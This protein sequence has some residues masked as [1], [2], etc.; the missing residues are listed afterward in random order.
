MRQAL[1]VILALALLGP[2]TDVRPAAAQQVEATLTILAGSVS[3]QPAAGG[4]VAPASE[5]MDVRNGDRVKTD[6]D[7]IALLTFVDGST[8]TMQPETEITV[9]RTGG[10]NESSRTSITIIL[11]TV[12]ARVVKLFDAQSEFTLEG[13][14]A[15]ATVRGSEIG[16]RQNADGTFVCWTRSGTMTVTGQG[17]S[18]TLEPG[19]ATTV[20]PGQT[21]TA[22]PFAVNQSVLRVTTASPIFPLLATPSPELLAG[23]AAPGIEVTQVFGSYVSEGLDPRVIEIPAGRPGR[24]ALMV[25]SAQETDFQIDLVAAHSGQTVAERQFTGRVRPGVG[26][27]A[28]VAVEVD[29]TTDPTTARIT[30]IDVSAFRPLADPAP[31]RLVLAPAEVRSRGGG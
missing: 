29:Q 4:S 19:Q 30:A 14:N 20:A 8:V 10:A 6:A 22:R 27:V 11:G 13:Q 16:A 15:T 24:Y 7:S 28:D 9:N 26:L 3:L 12:W 18:L 1:A 21:P 17:Q 23:F 25:E 31:G 5:G 2:S